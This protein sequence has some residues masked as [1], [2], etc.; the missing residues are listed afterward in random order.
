MAIFEFMDP[1]LRRDD[2]FSFQG[3]SLI[4]SEPSP[5]LAATSPSP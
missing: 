4:E 5:D 2:G 1:G 3:A